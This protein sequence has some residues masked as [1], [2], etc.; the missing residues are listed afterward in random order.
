M[1]HPSRDAE[2]G[3][4]DTTAGPLVRPFHSAFRNRSRLQLPRRPHLAEQPLVGLGV[5]ELL[6]L[7]VPL[8]LLAG[9][10]GDVAEV[11]DGGAAVADLGRADGR[12]AGL[13]TLQEVAHVAGRRR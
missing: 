12:L 4:A 7:R 8:Q 5:V 3:L 11:A 10:D 2:R 9:A 1:T 6:R 13:H